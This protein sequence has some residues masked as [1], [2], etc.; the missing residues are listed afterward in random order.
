MC[1]SDFS[2]SGKLGCRHLNIFTHLHRQL[3]SLFSVTSVATF[4]TYCVIFK[5]VRGMGVHLLIEDAHIPYSEGLSLN[6]GSAV[7]FGWRLPFHGHPGR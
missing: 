2:D 7:A 6:Y 3:T 5:A 4:A 1:V